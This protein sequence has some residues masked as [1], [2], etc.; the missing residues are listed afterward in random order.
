MAPELPHEILCSIIESAVPP[1]GPT[2]TENRRRWRALRRFALV[3]KAWYGAALDVAVSYVWIN[4][5]ANGW[6]QSEETATQ[7]IE[8]A[9]KR[10]FDLNR[11]IRVLHMFG[12]KHL[13]AKSAKSLLATFDSLEQMMLTKMLEPKEL[14]TGSKPLRELCLFKVRTPTISGAYPALTRLVLKE[15]FAESLPTWL[16]NDNFPSLETVSL[17]VGRPRWSDRVE[18]YEKTGETPPQKIR[19]L[20]LHGESYAWMGELVAALPI[21]EHLH[22]GIKLFKLIAIISNVAADLRSLSLAGCDTERSVPAQVFGPPFDPFTLATLRQVQSL[23]RLVVW[24]M[25][26]KNADVRSDVHAWF[27]HFGVL[28]RAGHLTDARAGAR[29]LEVINVAESRVFE[30][31]DWNPNRPLSA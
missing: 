1:P 23:E 24:P 4:L 9:K 30:P 19:A 5:H 26:M 3:R 21:L 15:C 20:A 6:S 2:Q 29:D 16:T 11:K 8:A 28:L 7:R 10:S 18:V 22:V 27:H 12:E 25:T 14:L 17:S 31:L 13:P